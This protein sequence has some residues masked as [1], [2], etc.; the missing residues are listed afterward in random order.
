MQLVLF[1]VVL[2]LPPFQS[3]G[4]LFATGTPDDCVELIIGGGKIKCRLGEYDDFD[5]YDAR[6]CQL[7]C[8]G[9][10]LPMP[11]VCSGN[12]VTCTQ[13]VRSTLLQWKAGL[14]N[15]KKKTYTM[16]W[17]PR[18]QDLHSTCREVPY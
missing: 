6:L 2:I 1:V 7:I 12:K 14:E 16:K 11:R 9:G 5:D 17:C 18:C 13:P 8:E 3:G 10:R 4:L 15:T